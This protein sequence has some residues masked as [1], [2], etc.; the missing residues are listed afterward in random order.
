MKEKKF[1]KL[2][3]QMFSEKPDDNAQ[4]GNLN[5]WETNPMTYDWEGTH[6]V[7][8]G[9]KEWYEK[10]DMEFWKISKVFAH[11][12]FPASPPFSKLIDFNSL[13][14]KCVLEIG[15]GM[16]A[17]SSLLAGSGAKLTSIDLTNNAVFNTRRRF[18]LFDIDA[19]VMRTDAEN[20]PFPD[21]TFDFV[22]SWGVIHH[23]SNTEQI[24]KEIHRV[25]KDNGRVS[26]M[27]YHRSSTRYMVYGG[28]YQGI[29][30]GRFLKHYSLY[31]VNMSFCDGY[32]ARHY[33]ASEGKELFKKFNSVKT[34][35]MDGDIP[36]VFYGWNWISRKIPYLFNPI[37]SF[38]ARRWGWFLYIDAVK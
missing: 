18:E 35:V 12:D 11:P 34:S 30:R 31:A 24:V 21:S 19:N 5:W 13:K 14:G 37:N 9:A 32:I 16:G 27:V 8:E 6:G 22:W 38:I 15:C 26:V 36:A 1:K 29:I 3:N 25:L 23:S 33:T 2:E 28:I 7:E 4:K 10:A 20:M 17:H